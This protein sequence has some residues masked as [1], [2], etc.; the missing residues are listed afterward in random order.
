MTR[1]A[2]VARA[3][4]WWRKLA[5]TGLRSAAAD[6]ASPVAPAARSPAPPKTLG[7]IFGIACCGVSEPVSPPGGPMLRETFM[8]EALADMVK[9]AGSG[10]RTIPLRWGHKGETV[11]TNR[12]LNL[13]FRV[14]SVAGFDA[15]LFEARLT[16]TAMN[17]RVLEDLERGVL[18]ASLGFSV[19]D[20][21]TTDRRGYGPVRVIR[22]CRL[23]HL[24]LLSRGSKLQ[25]AYRAAWA[26]GRR[27]SGPGCPVALRDAVE[28]AA[29]AALVAQAKVMSS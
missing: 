14:G 3:P 10:K 23:D 17:R 7:W 5:D 20:A 24:A 12:G 1:A 6:K 28:S 21:W 27:S 15:L 26:A 11:T 8:P 25:P 22:R 2:V 9:Q 18:G 19:D 16:D 13:L 4:E 29:R